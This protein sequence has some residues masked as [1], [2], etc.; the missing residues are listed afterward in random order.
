VEPPIFIVDISQM[1]CSRHSVHCSEVVSVA[2]EA[3]P[4]NL[5][6][7]RFP[8][9]IVHTTELSNLMLT[10]PMAKVLKKR[11]AMKRP[12]A[13]VPVLEAEV[14][15]AVAE[16]EAPVADAGAPVPAAPDYGIMYYSKAKTIGIRAK[17]GRKNQ[18][19]AFGKGS[20]TK[21]KAQMKKIGS[22]IVA[23]LRAGM[24]VADAKIKGNRLAGV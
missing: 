19:L 22:T 1:S 15:E 6:V 10:A 11:P 21:S 9:H 18:V 20:C 3:G 14:P 4:E 13:V 2:L 7:A 17:F 5:L 16:V 23:D 12:S 24:A 8:N